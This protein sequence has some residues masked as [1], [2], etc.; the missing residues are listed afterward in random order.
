MMSAWKNAIKQLG[1]TWPQLSDLGG[2]KSEA[3]KAYGVMSIPSNVLLNPEGKIIATDLRG[4]ELQQ[5]LA[6]LFE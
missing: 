4:E 6:D 5:V 1:M 2:W 3:A